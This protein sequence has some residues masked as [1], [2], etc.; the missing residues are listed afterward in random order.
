MSMHTLKVVYLLGKPLKKASGYSSSG[1]YSFKRME[2][3]VA[4]DYSMHT[5]ITVSFDRTSRTVCVASFSQEIAL[6]LIFN[7]FT[8]RCLTY[9]AGMTWSNVYTEDKK[10]VDNA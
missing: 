4:S 8:L 2:F 9:H 5:E 7:G 1:V 6:G 3:W 10:I